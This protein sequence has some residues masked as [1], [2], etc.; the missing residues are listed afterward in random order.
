MLLKQGRRMSTLAN[1]HLSQGGRKGASPGARLVDVARAVGVSRQV[2][3]KVLHGTGGCNTRVSEVTARSVRRAASKLN[4]RPNLI[5]RQ[6]S[7][8][9][10]RIIGLI[11]NHGGP[12]ASAQRAFLMED[13]AHQSDYRMVIGNA[14]GDPDRL[15]HYVDEFV[16]RRVEGIICAGFPPDR[17]KAVH[18]MIGGFCPVVFQS[19][20]APT[21]PS[22]SRAAFVS[23]DRFEACRTAFRHLIALGRRRI[24]LTLGSVPLDQPSRAE[25]LRGRVAALREAGLPVEESLV[26]RGDSFYDLL[27]R[28]KPGQQPDAVVCLTDAWAA[29]LCKHL[30]ARGIRVP[31]DVAVVGFENTDLGVHADITTFDIRPPK[32]ARVTVGA[33]LRLIDNAKPTPPLIFIKPTFMVRSSTDPTAVTRL[34][35]PEYPI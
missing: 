11:R 5:A 18:E 10:T 26:W 9:R 23:L 29:T 14:H 34:A 4:Y 13:V 3:A 27:E 25:P 19:A 17:A 15:K 20:Y 22:L 1:S 24:M 32:V 30:T 33:L 8:Q 16:D 21:Q 7:G 2:A 6:L 31:Q 35:A 12:P 28:F